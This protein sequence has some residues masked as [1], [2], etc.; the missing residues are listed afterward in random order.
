[1]KTLTAYFDGRHHV[2][3]KEAEID[4]PAKNEIQ[5][6]TLYNGI[7]MA[8]VWKYT[9]QDYTG[10]PLIPGHEGV[11]VVTGVG[12]QVEGIKEGDLVTTTGWSQYVNMQ[13]GA[14]IKLSDQSVCLKSHL[15]EPASCIVTA[16]EQLHIYPGS[17]VIVFG[18][19][20]MGLMLIQL[21]HHYPLSRLVVADIKPDVLAM[22]ESFGATETICLGTEEG[23]AKL[24]AYGEASFDIA[25]EC[26]G[27]QSALS[28][29]EKLLI[30]SGK[31]G[32]YAWHHGQ[33]L[34]DGHLWHTKGLSLL[35]VS[36]GIAFSQ[37]PMVPF[38]AA[39]RLMAAG[40]IHQEQLITH[41]F[42][43][44]DVAR[45][46][47]ASVKREAGFIKSVLKF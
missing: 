5:A 10:N 41:E 13:E 20:Y 26:S 7:C 31:L 33:R 46:M 15:V 47:E 17:S 11:G 25:Y 29:C 9:S 28:L 27:D 24:D 8:E 40:I 6:K 42:A 45:A 3:L 34:A 39:D 38:T 32:V 22:A 2:C 35:N 21:L 12:S 23:Q 4:G 37:K 30:K 18:A 43:F 14:F 1:M 36:P 44:E 19:G 16:A